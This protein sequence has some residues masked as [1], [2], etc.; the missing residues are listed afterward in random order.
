ME[1]LCFTLKGETAFFKKPEVNSYVYFTY[2]NIHKIAL[3]GIFGAILGYGG[4]AQ[5]LKQ[6]GKSK[7]LEE[8]F[9]DFYEKLKQ[10]KIAVSPNAEKGFIR[11]KIQTFN[12]SVGYASKETGGNLIVKEQWLEEPSWDIYVLSLIHI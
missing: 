7:Q 12:N 11:K 10:L 8:S 5:K 6:T 4:Y 1:S 2:G 3:L 9:P